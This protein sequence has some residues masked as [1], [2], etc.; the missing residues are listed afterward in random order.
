M[1]IH[2]VQTNTHT[3]LKLGAGSSVLFINTERAGR[4]HLEANFSQ[5]F[6]QGPPQRICVLF[7]SFSLRAHTFMKGNTLQDSVLTRM[8]MLLNPYLIHSCVYVCVCLLSSHSYLMNP[9]KQINNIP[10]RRIRLRV[11][12]K[13]K[14]GKSVLIRTHNPDIT[15]WKSLL[16]QQ[17]HFQVRKRNRAVTSECSNSSRYI[18]LRRQVTFFICSSDVKRSTQH[19]FI[20]N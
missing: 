14:G 15:E 8:A 7:R 11:D 5:W 17:N 20:C 6:H 18:E 3:S 19:L 9:A 10:Y 4:K 13:G 1:K 2:K 16:F 12:R